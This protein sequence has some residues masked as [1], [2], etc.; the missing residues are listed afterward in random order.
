MVVDKKTH[1]LQ[2]LR[3]VLSVAVYPIESMVNIPSQLLHSTLETIGSYEY[4]LTENKK[5]KRQQLIDGVRLLK[6]DALEKE[7]IRLRSLLD[8]SF[9]LGEQVLIAELIS[10]NL[11]PYEHVIVVNKGTRFGVHK[12]QAVLDANG[13]VGQVTQALPLSSEIILITDPSHA[14][15]VQVNRNGLHTIAMGSGLL[16]QLTLPFLPN[17][18]DIHPGD[19]LITS[20]LG[21]VFPQGYPV[22]V[23]ESFIEQPNKPF[24]IIYARPKAALNT[25]R[26]LL[27]V[28]NNNKVIPLSQPV[29]TEKDVKN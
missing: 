22:A 2:S 19:L 27:I 13:V 20:G 4:L 10:V 12:G 5:L 24:A 18:A 26:E 25:S 15:P 11:A 8:S 16:N 29:D 7:N 17:N 23:V 28:W 1:Y 6:F 14:I 21:G 3:A 9:K